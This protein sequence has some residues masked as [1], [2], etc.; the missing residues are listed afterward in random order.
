[1]L[2][3]PT[4]FI[5]SSRGC[6]Y[7]CGY[8]CTYGDSQ[9]KLIRSYSPK[10][11]VDNMVQLKANYGFKSFQFR[12]PVF[13][14]KKDFIDQFC[15]EIIKGGHKLI[16]GMETRSDLLNKDNLRLMALSGLKSI[17][18]GIETPNVEIASSNKRKTDEV[19]HQSFVVSF[20]K[21]L[22]IKVNAFYILGLEE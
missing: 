22:G 21:K 20:C 13:G 7:S 18:I 12:D 6:P 2:P 5:E 15:L 4:G 9:G 10:R 1:M 14:L 11:L 3:S 17:N 19:D 16:W 8:Y